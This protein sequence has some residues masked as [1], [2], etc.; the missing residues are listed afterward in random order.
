MEKFKS[1]DDKT[2]KN[3]I[4]R[5]SGKFGILIKKIQSRDFAIPP[6]GEVIKSLQN[7]L[8]GRYPNTVNKSSNTKVTLMSREEVEHDDKKT[9]LT[10]QVNQSEISST[11]SKVNDFKIDRQLQP[12]L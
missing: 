7:S 12:E 3:Q 9:L 6:K 8:L 5:K 10:P 1:D 2:S 11:N 4:P